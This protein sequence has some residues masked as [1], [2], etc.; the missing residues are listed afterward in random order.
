MAESIGIV[1][2]RGHTGAELIRLIAGHPHFEL[3]FVSSR[4]LDGQPVSEHVPEYRGDLRYSNLTPGQVAGQRADE[5]VGIRD[6]C[7]CFNVFKTGIGFAKSDVVK[8]GVIKKDRFLVHNPHQ[9]PQR[10]NG[11]VTDIYAINKNG[12][13]LWIIKAGDQV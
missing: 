7:G 4:E 11:T 5:V 2:A 10:F 1:G 13:L 6:T 12:P 9:T 3:A 8:N